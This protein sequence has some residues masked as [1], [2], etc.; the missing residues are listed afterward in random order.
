MDKWLVWWH[1]CVCMCVYECMCVYV[2]VC[3]Y[4]YACMCKYTCMCVY[5]CVC[6][7]IV[8]CPLYST[9]PFSECR[10]A[11]WWSVS[12][13]VSGHWLLLRPL[14]RRQSSL[15]GAWRWGGG[16]GVTALDSCSI[17]ARSRVPWAVKGEC[18]WVSEWVNEWVN[19][20]MSESVSIVC[21]YVSMWVCGY[22]SMW[23][24]EWV[25]EWVS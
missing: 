17:L 10:R 25:C 2:C 19:E 7:C 23:V 22:M 20:W 5:V 11:T 14:E 9:V 24:C 6:M 8:L 18:E 1:V 15:R 13:C 3:M 16:L 4:V 21:E 12:E